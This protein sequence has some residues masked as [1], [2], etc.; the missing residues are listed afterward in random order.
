[1]TPT[2][3]LQLPK[4]ETIS[5]FR[6]MADDA[7][8]PRDQVMNL[9]GR[10][11]MPFPKQLA[12]H[13]AA[14]MC[15]APDGPTKIGFGGA[16]GPGKTTCT[17]A[18]MALDDCQR[19]AGLKCLFVRQTQ[20]AASE[21]FEDLCLRLLRHQPHE[22]KA[23]K[24]ILKFP[25]GSRII[26]GG[27]ANDKDIDKYLGLE[28][29]L[30][31]IE[32]DTQLSANKKQKLLTCLRTSKTN[33][34][35]RSYHTTNPGGVDHAGYKRTF[36]EPYRRGV[37]KETRFI[38]ALAQ[39]N[40]A[41]NKEYVSVLEGLTGWLRKAWLF[42]DWDVMA[43]MYFTTYRYDKHVMKKPL[44]TVP[45]NWPVWAALDY[46]FVHP[47]VAY[48]FT[49]HE[50]I[51]YVVAEHVLAKALPPT[52]AARIKDL[53][54]K[55][56]VEIS[57]LRSFAAGADAFRHSGDLQGKTIA[58]Q[59]NAEGIRLRRAVDDRI[60]GATKILQILGD[61]END[62]PSKLLISPNCTRLI[63][64]LPVMQHDPHRVEDV[65]KVDVDD[66]GNGGDDGYDAFRYGVASEGGVGVHL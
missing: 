48:L 37:E 38:P 30:I 24:G 32:E 39:D 35:P 26:L 3:Q 59:Y 41:L 62:I 23:T 25:N 11:F 47:T 56:G 34:R 12:F 45:M 8:M 14:R 61:E 9:V 36:V 42:G 64:Q 6:E 21:S 29:D 18:Q 17:F 54:R 27:F 31:A 16:R 46:G 44:L 49:K 63:E 43:G 19:V 55:Y 40:P 65:L 50:G 10:G 1:M 51:Y 13:A 7:G 52:H 5:I 2:Q 15:D 20:K 4:K 53:F 22:H 57:R 66:D 58:D 28:Y 33:W 60:N